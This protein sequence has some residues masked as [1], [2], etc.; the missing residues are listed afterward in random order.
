MIRAEIDLLRGYIKDQSEV[1]HS[2]YWYDKRSDDFKGIN[3]ANGSYAYL[4]YTNDQADVFNLEPWNDLPKAAKI[5]TVD[6]V[7][8]AHFDSC[9]DAEKV[10]EKLCLIID[11]YPDCTTYAAGVDTELIYK[12]ETQEE[13]KDNVF[14]LVRIKFR[15]AVKKSFRCIAS[16]CEDCC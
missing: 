8:V 11:N 12:D 4:R 16:L 13:L 9:K 5:V 2:V 14:H 3:D 1:F 7:L 6:L 15:F 10:A